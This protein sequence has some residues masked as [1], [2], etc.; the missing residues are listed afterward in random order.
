MVPNG[1]GEWRVR[2]WCQLGFLQFVMVDNE[3]KFLKDLSVKL[4][5]SI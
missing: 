1:V 2:R 4:E 3:E 5:M